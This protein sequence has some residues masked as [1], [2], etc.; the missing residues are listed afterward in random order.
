[1]PITSSSV[2]ADASAETTSSSE[3]KT[4]LPEPSLAINLAIASEDL[5]RRES[6]GN[7]RPDERARHLVVNHHQCG[8]IGIQREEMLCAAAMARCSISMRFEALGVPS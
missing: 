3:F 6:Q 8:V 2:R 7:R 5:M 1:M 4:C